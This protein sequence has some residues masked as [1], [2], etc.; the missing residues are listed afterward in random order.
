VHLVIFQ[1]PHPS[2]EPNKMQN[3]VLVL[4]L[5]AA[6]PVT[7]AVVDPIGKVLDML[8]GL[9]QK[10]IKE[11]ESAQTLYNER[12]KYCEENA[13]QFGFEIKT[14]KAQVSELGAT[15]EAE[16]AGATALSTKIEDLS[17]DISSNEADLKAAAAMRKKENGNF[18]AE[19]AEMSQVVNSLERAISIITK[20][21]GSSASMLQV[22]S[23]SSVTEALSV[24]VQ[25]AAVSTDD[26]SKITA[27]VQQSSQAQ[28]EDSDSDSE[29]GAPAAAV[30]ENQSGGI[31]SVLEGLLDKA[32]STLDKARKAEATSRQ[33]YEMLKQ[34][35]TDEV[36][37]GNADMAEAKAGLAA[38]QESKAVAGGDLE[39]T[40]TDLKGDLAAKQDLH[41]SCMTTAQEFE[42]SVKSRAEEL[43]ALA[44]AKK[45]IQDSTAGAAAQSYGL[46][47]TSFVQVSAQSSPK[48]EAVRFVRNLAEHHRDAALTQLASRMNSAIRLNGPFDKVKG[49]ITDMLS[50]LEDAAAADATQKAYCDKET[51]ETKASLDDKSADVQALA[52]KSA[53]KSAMSSKLKEESA[54]LQSELASMTRSA[55][56]LTQLRQQENAAYKQNQP[57]MEQGLN[58]VKAA[59]K[60][61]RE[62][63][64]TASGDSSGIIG[65]LEVCE[66]DFSKGL[67]EMN[68][69][70]ETAAA[71]FEESAKSTE[72]EKAA[73]EKD[74][75]Y[76]TKEY[77]GLDKTVSE[78][79][80]DLSGSQQQLD[81]ISE[82]SAK[83]AS[84]CTGKPEPYE[85]RKK[86][87]E[88]EL[89]GLKE[90][91]TILEG[92]SFL[93]SKSTRRLRVAR[94]HA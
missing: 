11:G 53:Q 10:L 60:V 14:G 70:E 24:L 77:K 7:Q 46:A 41:H 79:S 71:A 9:Q 25:A 94:K 12:A 84:A 93:Q 32:Q 2:N 76:K 40:S 59:L 67:A 35:L 51:S 62:H 43:K 61:L 82:Y 19:E 6:L 36:R 55:G 54:T 68:V 3:F 4:A 8:G 66:S 27:L 64:G 56:E 18:V 30:T 52:T 57:E 73:K 65:L 48:Y 49:L 88:A 87:R 50:T 34:S 86:K 16:T 23:A 72:V 58:G 81:A 31:V 91:L 89:A 42:A 28:D 22:K 83:I 63:Y 78:L 80:G 44:T 33:N 75:S 5:V 38:A 17:A 26:A 13:Q 45:L 15:I 47:Q 74:L 39:S 29:M 90:A 20:E 1:N 69:Q 21:A 37:F 85:E 92:E